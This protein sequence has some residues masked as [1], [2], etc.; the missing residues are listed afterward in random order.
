MHGVSNT[1]E[2]KKITIKGHIWPC[3]RG[4]ESQE[5]LGILVVLQITNNFKAENATLPNSSTGFC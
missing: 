2:V 5:S 1:E 4:V 3:N